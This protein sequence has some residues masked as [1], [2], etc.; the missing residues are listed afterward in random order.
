MKNWRRTREYRRWRARVLRRDSRCIICGA[1]KTRQAHH[2]WHASYY[3]ELRYSVDNGVVLCRDHHSQFH[4]VML[5]G[6]RKKCTRKEFDRYLR[7]VEELT[8]GTYPVWGTSK[9]FAPRDQA[10]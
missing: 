3:P 2:I 8:N 4:N 10:G 7:L 9:V 5:G 6:T 1:L